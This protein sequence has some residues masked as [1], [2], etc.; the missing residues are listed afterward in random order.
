MLTAKLVVVGGD[1]KTTE[2]N[3]R[4][5]CVIGRGREVT[6]TLPHPLVSR[7]HCEIFEHEG[8]LYVKD[9]G[10]LNGTFINNTKIVGEQVL[11]PNQLLTLGNVTFRAIYEIGQCKI[12][13]SKLNQT[14]TIEDTVEAGFEESLRNTEPH[15]QTGTAGQKIRFE[16][17]DRQEEVGGQAADGQPKRTAGR[18]P[19][20]DGAVVDPETIY[21]DEQDP[22]G[23]DT[24]VSL[25]DSKIENTPP[26]GV[27][28]DLLDEVDKFGD[29]PKSI[30]ASAIDRLPPAP[31][32]MS[33]AAGIELD[34]ENKPKSAVDAV[35]LELGHDVPTKPDDP[36]GIDSFVKSC[37]AKRFPAKSDPRFASDSTG[38]SASGL[39]L[40][41]V[42]Y[43]LGVLPNLTPA[44]RSM[45][46][47][48]T[49]RCCFHWQKVSI[50][51][52]FP[53]AKNLRLWKAVGFR[54]AAQLSGF[55][56][57]QRHPA[58]S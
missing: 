25:V 12:E 13:P 17:E 23:S 7:R 50:G 16:T 31:S 4:F 56:S 47:S 24:D 3:L 55:R 49:G 32:G 58:L 2:V 44:L 38:G 37:L 11:N 21:D 35:D 27:S 43:Y 48:Q 22:S 26:S 14:A 18:Q 9:L 52:K 20:T 53:L 15:K 28:S 45:V 1:A 30:S 33:F 54:L 39:P 57:L 42:R 10:S 40:Q 19:S 34:D 46:L 6:L 36:S 29:A 8:R 41:A 51:K 5:P